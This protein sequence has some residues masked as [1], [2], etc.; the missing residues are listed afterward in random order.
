MKYILI[1]LI[2]FFCVTKVNCQSNKDS[3]ISIFFKLY[4]DNPVNAYESLFVKSKWMTAKNIQSGKSQ[5]KDFINDL[6]EYEGYEFITEKQAGQS[7]ILESFLVKYERQPV[8]FTFILYRPL[9]TWQLQDFTYDTNLTSEITGAAT[10][11]KL[12]MNQ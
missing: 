4:K 12:K 7:Y 8:R 5:L 11:D 9:N 1:L 3:I 2:S 6:G 10:I